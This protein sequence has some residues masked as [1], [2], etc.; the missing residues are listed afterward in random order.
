MSNIVKAFLDEMSLGEFER[1][2]DNIDESARAVLVAGLEVACANAL[3]DGGM[4]E[5]LHGTYMS[6]DGTIYSEDDLGPY[7]LADL[8]GEKAG[9]REELYVIDDGEKSRIKKGLMT[10]DLLAVVDHR[11][12]G[13]IL[14]GHR[15][16]PDGGSMW[17]LSGLSRVWNQAELTMHLLDMEEA[18]VSFIVRD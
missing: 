17:R 7:E 2:W 8:I 14:S 12:D 6:K 5:K 13:V 3:T 1:A 18:F 16:D 10:A 11:T 15:I 4:V 9:S